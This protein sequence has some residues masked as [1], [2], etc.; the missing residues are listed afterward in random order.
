MQP[1]K[2]GAAYWCLLAE[3]VLAFGLRAPSAL[4]QFPVETQQQANERIRALSAST[5]T[6]PREY[7]IG[8]GDVI[9]V[10]VYDVPELTRELRVSQTGT[11]GMPLVPVRLYVVGLTEMQAQQKISEILAANGLVTH[12]QVMVSVKEKRSKPITIVGAVAH[13]MVYQADRPTTLVQVLAEAGG[14]SPDAGDTV[15]VTR[16]ESKDENS[17]EPPEIGTEDAVAAT[18]PA[19]ASS[20]AP[21]PATNSAPGADG[22][23]ARNSSGTQPTFPGTAIAAQT[24]PQNAMPPQ[25]ADSDIAPPVANTITVNLAELLERGDTQNNIPLQGGD[26]VTVP[27]AGIVY[28]LGA[29]QRPG[30]F[31]ANNDRA[32]L[33]TLKVLALAGGM[34]RIARKNQAVIIR[35]DSLGKQQA[36]QVDLGKIIE[37]KSEDVRLMPSDILYVPDNATKAAL[38]RA[39]EFGLAV[40]TALTIYRIGTR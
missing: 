7:I 5:V 10:E 35:K 27:H 32:Q 26:I 33:S 21:I 1:A 29:V 18:N 19:L 22:G 28:A 23:A 37:R 14:I 17:S 11:V 38:I 2:L 25:I 9:G 3:A 15:I 39:G 6:P 20:S 34:T 40:G 12:P 24:T 4:A 16:A 13:P 31:V 8:K 30:G 36:I